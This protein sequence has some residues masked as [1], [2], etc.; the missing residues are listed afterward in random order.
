[1]SARTM[2]R[3]LTREDVDR[4]RFTIWKH[5]G[6]QLQ[7]PQQAPD[8]VLVNT[9]NE[10]AGGRTTCPED[11]MEPTP[12]LLSLVLTKVGT[13]QA[14]EENITHSFK[15]L[16]DTPAETLREELRSLGCDLEVVYQKIEECIG[17][18]L[19]T[20]ALKDWI[21]KILWTPQWAGQDVTAADISKQTHTFTTE[22]GDITIECYWEKATQYDPAYIWLN[23]Q[24]DLKSEKA[25]NMLFVNPETQGIY[26][27]VNM[28]TIYT[29]EETFT[30]DELGFDPSCERW[31]LSVLLQ[32]SAA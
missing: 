24:A 7:P 5:F 31:A 15:K 26:H 21:M 16:C 9:I 10:L 22:D 32:E 6:A 30:D 1:M 11:K 12:C 20:Q 8:D 14:E 18:R 25:L 4:L 2:L 27:Q 19:L 28:K 23:W 29:G 3:S 17:V 13:Q